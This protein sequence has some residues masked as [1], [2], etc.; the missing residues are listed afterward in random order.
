LPIEHAWNAEAKRVLGQTAWETWAS[1]AYH[2]T[3]RTN[4]DSSTTQVGFMAMPVRM[5]LCDSVRTT[6]TVYGEH[7][8][9]AIETRVTLKDSLPGINDPHISLGYRLNE[10]FTASEVLSASKALAAMRAATSAWDAD[11]EDVVLVDCSL[12]VE[13]WRLLSPTLCAWRVGV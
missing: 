9:H 10:P 8:F 3:I 7:T 5:T 12:P 4:V 2:V 1:H 11:A 13:E 6:H